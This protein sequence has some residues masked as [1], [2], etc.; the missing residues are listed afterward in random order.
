[1]GRHK[2][3]EYMC[4]VLEAPLR[5]PHG[6]AWLGMLVQFFGSI[7]DPEGDAP[8]PQGT[9]LPVANPNPCNFVLGK[10]RPARGSITPHGTGASHPRQAC[11]GLQRLMQ[12]NSHHCRDLS[13]PSKLSARHCDRSG[14]TETT[15][16]SRFHYALP[17]VRDVSSISVSDYCKLNTA[18]EA[19]LE[20][21]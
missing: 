9:R 10:D 12:P 14:S 2:G 11:I 21:K 8:I 7:R 16:A 19:G 5:A 4:M 20:Q 18:A 1:M 6:S 3:T 17:E 13:L 15:M